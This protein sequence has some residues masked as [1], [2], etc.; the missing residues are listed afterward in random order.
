MIFS[1]IIYRE[2]QQ[3]IRFVWKVKSEWNW[4]LNVPCLAINHFNTMKEKKKKSPPIVAIIVLFDKKNLIK[5][6]QFSG[7]IIAFKI[8]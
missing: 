4:L 5:S 8:S 2:F 3:T 1:V 7:S 6:V